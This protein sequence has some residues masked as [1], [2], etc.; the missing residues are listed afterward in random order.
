M[1]FNS[2]YNH[3]S[4]DELNN[5]SKKLWNAPDTLLKLRFYLVKAIEYQESLEN[6][7]A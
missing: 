3:F 2:I 7:T 1:R 6:N 5:K 4:C